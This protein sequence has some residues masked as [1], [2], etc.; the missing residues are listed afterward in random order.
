MVISI[1]GCEK[2]SLE[3]FEATKQ[4]LE[5]ILGSEGWELYDV[6]FEG[7]NLAKLYF[8]KSENEE[9]NWPSPGLGC[10]SPEELDEINSIRFPFNTLAFIGGEL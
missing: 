7:A 1:S 10:L 6:A 8:A 5:K 9:E 4:G 2:M 3:M